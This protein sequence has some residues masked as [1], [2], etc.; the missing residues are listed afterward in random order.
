MSLILIYT[1]TKTKTEA[2]KIGQAL[3]K[4][5]LAGCVN[6]VDKMESIYVWDNKVE[7]SKET[8]LL[9]KTKKS[10]AKKVMAEIKKMHS[11]ECPCL[12]C[13]PIVDGDKDYIN[14]LISGI[15]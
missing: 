4:N 1:T 6:I 14:W 12:I 9:I 8:I 7:S 13:L 2:K 5:R 15:Q 3:T 11:Y 10:L